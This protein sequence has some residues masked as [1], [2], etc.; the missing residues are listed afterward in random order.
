M[1]FLLI[2]FSLTEAKIVADTLRDRLAMIETPKGQR[3]CRVREI[4]A[5]LDEETAQI[6]ENLLT[7]SKTSLRSIHAELQ[8]SN[9]R[10]A[11]EALGVHRNNW[12]GCQEMETA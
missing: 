4:K 9:I 7:N 10:V 3:R 5:S 12:C 8:A 1:D 11:R 6:L 2:G